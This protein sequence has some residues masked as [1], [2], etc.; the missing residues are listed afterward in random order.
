ME[1]EFDGQNRVNLRHFIRADD[2]KPSDDDSS[3]ESEYPKKYYYSPNNPSEKFVDDKVVEERK[4]IQRIP[5]FAIFHKLAL[6]K[7]VPHT[8]VGEFTFLD[9]H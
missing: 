8:F 2:D 9:D 7:G 5:T 4:E 3:L 1:D 6:G